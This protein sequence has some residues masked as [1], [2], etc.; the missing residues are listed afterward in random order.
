MTRQY[1]PRPAARTSRIDLRAEVAGRLGM[2]ADSSNEAL[3]DEVSARKARA[4]AVRAEQA[5]YATAFGW[6][7]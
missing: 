2:P 3:L 5:L 6:R 7:E 1:R 4:D